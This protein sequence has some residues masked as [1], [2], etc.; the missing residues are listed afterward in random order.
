MSIT[1]N[2]RELRK[3][4][5]GC[6]QQFPMYTGFLRYGEDNSTAFRAAHLAHADTGPHLWLALGS[7][8]WFEDDERGCWLVLHSWLADG[9]LVTR[10]EEPGDSP[11]RPEDVFDERLLTRAEVMS[12]DGGL[13]WAMERGEQFAVEHR[14]TS[15]FFLNG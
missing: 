4:P 9:N 14:P 13:Q 11:F 7:G 6:E 5:C 10:V 3:C 2:K 1:S 8:P 15:D 12:H